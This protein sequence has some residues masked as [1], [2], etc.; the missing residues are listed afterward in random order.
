MRSRRALIFLCLAVTSCGPMIG[1]GPKYKTASDERIVQM[2][3]MP[4]GF[5]DAAVAS[6]LS[7]GYQV[8]QANRD[9]KTVL[10]ARSTNG[11]SVEET[12]RVVLQPDG[13]GMLVTAQIAGNYDT[14]LQE[15]PSQLIIQFKD[16]MVRQPY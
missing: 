14:G 15:P 6:G 13:R 9:E 2:S 10:L 11:N 16:A 7:L 3:R 4:R 12:L 8:R 1:A 5:V